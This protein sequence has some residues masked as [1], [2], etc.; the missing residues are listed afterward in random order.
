MSLIISN[1]SLLYNDL[2]LILI[3][4]IHISISYLRSFIL[5]LFINFN[6]LLDLLQKLAHSIIAQIELVPKL[7]D[8]HLWVVSIVNTNLFDVVSIC[9][10]LDFQD[11]N[12][13]CLVYELF[14]HRTAGRVAMLA[15]GS[16][17]IVVL[18]QEGGTILT[19]WSVVRAVVPLILLV[20]R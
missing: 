20:L 7:R 11:A 15:Y 14:R 13:R 9:V 17:F 4:F 6:L 5:F 19:E 16:M 2:F 10:E 3:K 18:W 12:W 1:I 8:D